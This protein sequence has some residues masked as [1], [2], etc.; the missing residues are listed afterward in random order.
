MNAHTETVK[1]P[2]PIT[3]FVISREESC[4]GLPDGEYSTTF[5]ALGF[6]SD[7]DGPERLW[8]TWSLSE[9]SCLDAARAAHPTAIYLGTE[10]PVKRGERL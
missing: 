4:W 9:A 2:A 5:I 8:T 10:I 3:A 6:G 1:P 7:I